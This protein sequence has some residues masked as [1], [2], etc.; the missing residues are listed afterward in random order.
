M[1]KVEMLT[2]HQACAKL[3][4]KLGKRIP[5]ST[6]MRWVI[7]GLFTRSVKRETPRGPYYEIPLDDLLSFNPPAMGRPRKS[8]SEG[9]AK[10]AKIH[11]LNT[12][13]HIIAQDNQAVAQGNQA[14]SAPEHK[15]D[16]ASAL[17]IDSQLKD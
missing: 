9:R 6:L 5:Y 3:S 11:H 8:F 2:T 12:H 16:D 14:D 17:D 13:S 4:E 10:R 7:G 1:P 15:A